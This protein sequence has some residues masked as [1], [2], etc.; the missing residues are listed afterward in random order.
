MS[1]LPHLTIVVVT[2]TRGRPQMLRALIESWGAM[3]VPPACDLSCL[4]VENA[5]RPLSLPVVQAAR[6]L[7]NGLRVDHLLEPEPG[8]PFARNRAAREVIARGADLLAFVDDDEVVARDWLVKFVEGYR[9]SG[10][11]LLGAPLRIAPL[12][13][14]V[15]WSQR[16]MYRNVAERYRRKETRA[17]Q[18]AGLRGTPGVTIVTNNW[19]AE[20]RLF[21]DHGIW[22]DE[23]MR[24]TGG[25]DAKFHAE[26]RRRGLPTAWVADAV[27]HEIVPADRLSFRY[28]FRRGR[29]Q[30]N[31]AFHRKLADRPFAWLGLLGSLPLRLALVLALAV[32]LPFTQGRTLLPLARG[33]GWI[34]GRIGAVLGTRSRLYQNVTGV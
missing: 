27:V 6:P 4:V 34:A 18:R 9:A 1:S 3:D 33:L 15:G 17:A 10:A 31:T 23:T 2:L 26:V 25:T 19:L 14:P 24:H 22:F 16:L 13:G 28:Q 30:S 12:M 5:L 7:P 32:A 20:T 21:R 29:D 8:I 11:M